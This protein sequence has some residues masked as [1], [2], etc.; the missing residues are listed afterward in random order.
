MLLE[1]DKIASF[2]NIGAQ[3][4]VFWRSFS[5][6]STV[7]VFMPPRHLCI[8]NHPIGCRI[9][10]IPM[11]KLLEFPRKS[12]TQSSYFLKQQF[13]LFMAIYGSYRLGLTDKNLNNFE[14]Q[15]T[16]Q[17]F[18]TKSRGE[19]VILTIIFISLMP[20]RRSQ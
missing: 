8:H 11:L 9:V 13:S 14:T 17:T 1:K 16:R 3:L 7:I 5:T 10:K 6:C 12:L 15:G 4:N 20:K 18:V 2:K 19:S